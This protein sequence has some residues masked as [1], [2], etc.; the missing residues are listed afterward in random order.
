MG[1]RNHAFIDRT[2]QLAR[3]IGE[4][5]PV[6]ASIRDRRDHHRVVAPDHGARAEPG[7]QRRN[8]GNG[9]FAARG[10]GVEGAGIAGNRILHDKRQ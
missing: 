5:S 2:G 9:V 6:P 1:R 8:L 7:G 4:I 3:D 10:M